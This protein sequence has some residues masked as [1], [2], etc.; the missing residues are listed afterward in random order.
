MLTLV[1][2]RARS[3]KTSFVM[4]EIK[5]RVDSRQGDN[6]LLVPEQYSHQ[7][8]RALSEYCGDS[9]SLYGEVLT[10][11]LLADR[12]LAETGGLAETL[13]DEGGRIL[14]M[15]LAF[16]SVQPSLKLYGG[17]TARSEFLSGLLKTLDE[18]RSCRIPP[19]ELAEKAAFEG[20]LADKLHDLS[21]I[22]E[23][24]D[25][26]LENSLRDPAERL[27]RLAEKIGQSSIGRGRIYIDGFSDFTAQEL[28]VIR[29]L[30]KKGAELTI[31]LPAGGEDVFKLSEST[32]RRLVRMADSLG[33]P[34]RTVSLPPIDGM[35]APELE[36]LER[37]LFTTDKTPFE[38]KKGAVSLISAETPGSECEIAAAELIRLVRDEGYRW[39]DLAVTARGFENYETLL[40]NTFSKYGIPLF[41][42]RKTDILQ[43]PVLCLITSA[44]D[45]VT[46]GWDYLSMFRYLKTGLTG[47]S[48][49]E[50]DLLENYVLKWNIRGVS[51]WS[52]E[53]PW[54]FNPR[55]YVSEYLDSDR[56]ILSEI[57]RI[58]RL[59][60]LPLKRYHEAAKSAGTAAGQ[61]RALYS[62]MEDISLPERLEEKT[63]RFR[64]IG[65]EATAEEYSQLWDILVEVLE[66]CMAILGELPMDIEEFSRLLKL[67]LSKYDV[68]TIPVSLD[69]VQAGDM[70]R[71][72]VGRVKCLIVLG[73]TDDALPMV[74]EGAGVLTDTER[75]RLLELGFEL[76]GG[77]EERISREMQTIYSCLAMPTER[78]VICYPKTAGGAKKRPSYIV[79]RVKTLLNIPLADERE[80]GDTFRTA[81][82]APCFELAVTG[83]QSELAM[84]A[85]AVFE[86]SPE[87]RE[88][89]GKALA[90][91]ATGRGSLH[92]D[93]VQSIYGKRLRL[94]A[95]RVDRFYSCKFSYFMQYG[96]KAR[97]RLKAE[98]DAP[99]VGTF[100]HFVLEN[101]I[102]ELR[103]KG[104][105]RTAEREEYRSLAEKYV[106][107]YAQKRLGGLENKSGR[108]KYLFN[109]LVRDVYIIIDDIVEELKSSEFIPL[110]FELEFGGGAMPAAE[111]R[112][113]DMEISVSGIV[114][115]VDGWL[116]DGK[117][118][119]RVVDYKT[120]RKSFD[121]SDVW[122]GLGMQMLIYLF[123][124][125]KHGKRFYGQEI[126]PAGVLYAPARDVY[127]SLPR[128]ATDEEIRKARAKSLMRSGLILNDE[129]VIEAM[130][131]GEK[132]FIPVKF[133]KDGKLRPENLATLEQL[134]KLGAHIEETLRNIGR[135]LQCGN[136]E[137][138]PFFKGG[139]SPCDYCDYI[140]A[141]LFDEERDR[142]RRLRH[143]K[144]EEIWIELEKKG[145]A[146]DGQ[147]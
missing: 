131:K 49:E 104:T 61:I 57:D 71:M 111:V 99:E 91:A 7:S 85:R 75:E 81:A 101:V 26:I 88:M 11:S 51:I 33:V 13:L 5:K 90:A 54:S 72:R 42:N 22:C 2:G 123:T 129:E 84:A 124:L 48:P 38:G 53:E 12:V 70:T 127:L 6:I 96:L 76:T 126:V 27:D 19:S 29:E 58:R 144:A 139:M 69:A 21:L 77:T 137:A 34:C 93:S 138:D 47:I 105:L 95:S 113:G 8:A 140:E 83:G 146:G 67:V 89:L 43:K 110:S 52:S 16:A 107:L 59:A 128:S 41:L 46:R 64:E 28:E 56:E 3:G 10:F 112:D 44:M 18:L 100:L 118:Y 1:T 62:F 116:H 87:R 141:C 132:R 23:A 60:A 108:F 86:R 37:R 40:E 145:G 135:E 68:S 65:R 15:A 55:G 73:A 25:A 122:Y 120:G 30:M 115:R 80:L 39:R 35:A 136:I 121:L 94:T 103:K 114:D 17:V 24:Y 63:R 133:T 14:V 147:G 74:G 32:R 119:L 109:R 134:G 125:E 31:T 66:Q 97:P 106:A 79:G 82:E 117:L 45:V 142:R 78:L 143:R 130:E 98:L 36:H 92:P 4:N 102:G 9:L 20:A 50:C